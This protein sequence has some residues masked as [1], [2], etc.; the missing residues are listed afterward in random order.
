MKE[1]DFKRRRERG[2]SFNG[3]KQPWTSFSVIQQD[4]AETQNGSVEMSGYSSA[5]QDSLH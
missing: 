3:L 5:L 2:T 4:P 1:S